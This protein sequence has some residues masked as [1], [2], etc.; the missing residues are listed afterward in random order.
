MK[1]K[2]LSIHLTL[3]ITCIFL[4]AC[5]DDDPER[6]PVD[7]DEVP[8]QLD[9]NLQRH[10]D[11]ILSS[12]GWIEDTRIW[13]ETGLPLG[14]DATEETEQRL[15][16]MRTFLR[17][18]VFVDPHLEEETPLSVTYLLDG[19][20]VCEG[21]DEELD[22]DDFLLFGIG[23]LDRPADD[24]LLDPGD[25]PPPATPQDP[26][27]G[28]EVD[29]FVDPGDIGD[30]GDPNEIADMD[31]IGQIANLIEIDE[32]G[33]KTNDGFEDFDEVG[34][35]DGI[36][37]IAR[38]VNN[39]DEV[40]EDDVAAFDRTACAETIDAS[41]LR[42]QVISEATDQLTIDLLVGDLQHNPVEFSID[43]DSSTTQLDLHELDNALGVIREH[44]DD[45]NDLATEN[46]VW[47]GTLLW[48]FDIERDARIRRQLGVEGPIRIETA[49]LVL[50]VETTDTVFDRWIDGNTGEMETTVDWNRIELA[51][52]LN[53][54]AMEADLADQFDPV[55]DEQYDEDQPIDEAELRQARLVL[56]GFTFQSRLTLEQDDELAISEL[57]I[58]EPLTLFFDDEPQ[59][60]LDWGT[61]DGEPLDL[62]LRAGEERT[63]LEFASPSELIVDFQFDERTDPFG[64]PAWMS[65]DT[66]TLRLDEADT[67]TLALHALPIIEVVDGRFTV[68]STRVQNS[69][70][71][72]PRDCLDAD[73]GDFNAFNDPGFVQTMLNIHPL[74]LFAV[75]DC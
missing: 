70:E 17:E 7:A 66:W 68:E 71:A 63:E 58:D 67:P 69:V 53:D 36:E 13:Q 59:F 40:A 33:I 54:D 38:V 37:P 16:S 15:D 48:S 49:G 51:F 56:D 46:D 73:S 4:L 60:T 43:R 2:R 34:Q 24:P 64:M 45:D 1:P 19:E 14:I 52:D 11:A 44:R 65:D 26:E 74:Q 41:E 28:P 18:Y 50:D 75:D 6:V 39:D 22:G 62:I 35:I 8:D 20:R 12:S 3:V 25:I 9:Q 30:V 29:D 72:Q 55:D 21:I 32:I 61:V 31:A 10:H 27:E 23:L 42:L 5:P 57:S 47:S